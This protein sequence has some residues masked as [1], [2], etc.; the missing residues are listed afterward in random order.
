VTDPLPPPVSPVTTVDEA[1]ARMQ[2]IDRS[3]PGSD[4]V[5]CFNRMYLEVTQDVQSH[6]GQRSFSDPT[7]L[8]ALDVVF[9]NLYVN[10]VYA[11]A[12]PPTPIPVAWQPLMAARTKPGVYSIQ[13][14]RAGMDAHINH[15]LPLA[16]VQTCDQ[17]GTAP[18]DGT[19]HDDY[20][21][22]DTLLDSAEQSARQSFESGTALHADRDAQAVLDLVGNWSIDSARDVAWDTG[23]AL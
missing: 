2:A 20:R 22:V 14:A 4:G 17:L 19:H 15:D 5:A 9:A 11:L 23:L 13:F 8:G 7:L 21:K 3:L 1:I 12:T 6:I 18:D 10:A 16:L